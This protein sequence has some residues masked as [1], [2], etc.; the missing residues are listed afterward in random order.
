MQSEDLGKL[1]VEVAARTLIVDRLS[2]EAAGLLSEAGI[3][4]MIFKGPVIGEWLYP[5]E[6][7]SYGDSDFLVSPL[8]WDRAVAVLVAQG[9]RMPW[10]R[11]RIPAWSRLPEPRSCADRTTST[12]TPRSRG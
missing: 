4:C 5:E 10:V 7:R 12:C 6:A 1:L 2:A 3:D 11:W 9:F 8:D